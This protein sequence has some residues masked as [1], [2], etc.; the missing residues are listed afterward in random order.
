MNKEDAVISWKS[1]AP[2]SGPTNAFKKD[3]PTRI[4]FLRQFDYNLIGCS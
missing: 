3:S 2:G 1:V 4:A